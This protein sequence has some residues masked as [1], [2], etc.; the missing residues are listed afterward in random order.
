MLILENEDLSK[1]VTFR[2]GGMAEK[3]YI[4]ESRKE[5]TELL[6]KFNSGNDRVYILGGGSN[7]LINDR[8]TFNNVVSM[9]EMDRTINHLGEGKFYAGASVRLQRLILTV[10][11]AGY[12]GIEYLYSVPGTVGGAVVMNAGRGEKY[13]KC[14]SDYITS[15]DVLKDGQIE[16]LLKQSCGF[17]YRNSV[18]KG[19]DG[20]ILGAYFSF[21]EMDEETSKSLREERIAYTKEHHDLSK[22]NFGSLFMEG[23]PR[24]YRILKEHQFGFK[25][26]VHFSSKCNN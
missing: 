24:V 22:P 6:E 2:I 5:L 11:E 7:L 1:H 18:F 3:F 16:N 15:V 10:N 9:G 12:G 17:S 21:P 8:K 14:I 4:P 26:G 13:H 20:V 23:S 25:N 19:N